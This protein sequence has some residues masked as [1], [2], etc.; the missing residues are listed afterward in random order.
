MAAVKVL[1]IDDDNAFVDTV[2]FVLEQQGYEMLTASNG[3]HG[4]ALAIMHRP[5]VI[6]CDVRMG[7][8]HGYATAQTL[9]GKQETEKIPIIMITGFASPYGERRSRMAG[10]DYYL[11][12]PVSIR[13]LVQTL[14]QALKQGTKAKRSP[15]LIFPDRESER[16]RRKNQ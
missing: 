4:I 11:S 7:E 9:R 2:A 3:A 8:G 15:D 12:K 6:L 13:D 5:D 10:A 16:E 1:I 14:E